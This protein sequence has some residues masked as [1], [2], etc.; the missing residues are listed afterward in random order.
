MKKLVLAL[1]FAFLGGSFL[2]AQNN[3]LEDQNPNHM[4][5]MQK[6][7]DKK[8]ELNSTQSTTSQQTYYVYDRYEFKI[9]RKINKQDNK[10][11]R[12]LAKINNRGRMN[13]ISPFQR[14]G[15][16]VSPFMGFGMN[17]GIGFNQGYGN[18]NR[19]CPQGFNNF[20][21]GFNLW[22]NGGFG[23]NW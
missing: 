16:G 10:Q 1:F 15:F 19:N 9:N 8:D 23:F 6:Y 13:A 17:N 4:K 3:M 2:Q 14:G 11:E 5:S 18:F 20:N 22:N 12:R 21:N 7:M